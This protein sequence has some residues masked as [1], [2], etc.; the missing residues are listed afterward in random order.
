MRTLLLLCAAG[1]ALLAASTAANAESGRT[2]CRGAVQFSRTPTIVVVLR[3]VTCAEAKRVVRAY[4]RGASAGNWRC[5]LAHA[6][7]DRVDGRVV[8]FS[9]GRGGSRGNLR[10]WPHAFL[11]TIAR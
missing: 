11:G 9:C 6:P 1:A 8:G 5:A 3:G 10:K 7:F 2:T 4:D